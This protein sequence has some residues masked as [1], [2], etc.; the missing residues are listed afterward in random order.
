MGTWVSVCHLNRYL[1]SGGV[2]LLCPICNDKV[3]RKAKNLRYCGTIC[4]KVGKSVQERI[5]RQRRRY[6]KLLEK[7]KIIK[8]CKDCTTPVNKRNTYC[9][10]CA[11]IRHEKSAQR[12]TLKSAKMKKANKGDSD[13]QTQRGLAK[14]KEPINPYFLTRGK[15]RNNSTSS[16]MGG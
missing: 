4:Y 11:Q 6:A 10:P 12:A 14:A 5:I 16:I 1:R 7:D 15:V 3:L 9:S 13:A 2:V 8:T